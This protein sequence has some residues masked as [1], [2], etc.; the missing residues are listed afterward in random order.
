MQHRCGLCIYVAIQTS[1][2]PH[3]NHSKQNT[4][5]ILAGSLGQGGSGKV[6][7][8]QAADFAKLGYPVDLLLH[9]R[10]SPLLG[11]VPESVRRRRLAS[12]HPVWGVL[13]L[14]RYLRQMRPRAVLVHRP[15]LLRP[16]LR[17]RA[18]SGM[19][20]RIV[21]VIHTPLGPQL[22]SND[23]NS[24]RRLRTLQWLRD[25][26]ALVAVSAGTAHDAAMQL[27][28][29]PAALSVAYPPVDTAALRE[30]AATD[31]SP[32]GLA[33][34]LIS[35]GRLEEEKDFSTLLRAFA[36]VGAQDRRLE[37]VILGEGRQRHDLERL[38]AKLGIAERVQLPGFIPNPYPWIAGARL[39]ALSSRREGFGMVLAEALAL[40]IPVVATD[41]PCGPR[42]ILDGGRYGHLVP[43][44]DPEALATA[45]IATLAAPVESERLRQ[46]TERFKPAAATQVYLESLGFTPRATD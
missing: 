30:L 5:A 7:V 11:A 26:E 20:C 40:G 37:L 23:G 25:C 4:V 2:F 29:P 10:D 38:A 3:A 27:G 17:A 14:F 44:G 24:R 33:R 35:I 1:R 15:R 46:A 9:G 13:S 12:L 22:E 39:L 19:R 36:R 18:L 43:P 42:E 8:Q 32:Q 45:I 28:L 41:C 6:I 31:S 21:A 34:Y 16:L